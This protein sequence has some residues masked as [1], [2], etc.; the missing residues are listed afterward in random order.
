[1]REAPVIRLAREIKGAQAGEAG[2][3]P[4]AVLGE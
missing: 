1:L 2:M 4:P 3:D